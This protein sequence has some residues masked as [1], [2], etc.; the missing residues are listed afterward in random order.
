MITKIEETKE[1]NNAKQLIEDFNKLAKEFSSKYRI[2]KYYNYPHL[3]KKSWF[4]DQ[5]IMQIYYS[6]IKDVFSFVQS[7]E[8]DDFDNIRLILEKIPQKFEVE[9]R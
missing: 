3:F 5:P 1:G 4:I 9:I 7:I 8:Q 2:Y 6:N